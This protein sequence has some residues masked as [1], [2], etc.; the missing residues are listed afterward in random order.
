MLA[1]IRKER[2]RK[3]R[4]YTGEVKNL[5]NRY[6]RQHQ[7]LENALIRKYILR[8][9]TVHEKRTYRKKIKHID[10]I[11]QRKVILVS[12]EINKLKNSNKR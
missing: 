9:P 3:K 8:I 4:S 11:F 12:L 6:M 1:N 5:I 2:F 10:S 7:W